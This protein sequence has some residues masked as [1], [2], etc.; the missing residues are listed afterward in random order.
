MA[1]SS[2]DRFGY[3]SSTLSST[4]D[5]EVRAVV[6]NVVTEGDSFQIGAS[7]LNR[8][9]RRRRLKV[10]M[11][12][13]GPLVGDS[14]KK[15]NQ[16]VEFQPHERKLV[17]WD[18]AADTLPRSLDPREPLRTLEIQV[19]ASA[20][21]R[22]DK[23]AL[24]VQIPVRSNQVRVSSVVYGALDG[25]K[26][27][28]PIGIPTKLAHENGRLDFTLTTND[29][30]NFDGVFQYVIDYPYSC[31][32]Q[33]LTKA[34]LA[35]QYVQLEKRGVKHGTEWRDPE[36]LIARVLATAVDYQVPNG[37]MA[38]FTPKYQFEDPYLSA[39]TAIAFSWLE[40]AGYTVPGKVKRKLIEY[41]QK[42][43][44]NE[45][46]VLTF[47]VYHSEDFVLDFLEATVGA[48]VV[49]ALAVSGELTEN[50][51]AHYSGHINQ[52][53]LFG[54]SQYLLA[55]LI[56]D[57]THSTIKRTFDRIMNHR[58]LVDGVVEFVESVPRGFTRI[59]HSDTRSL[60][61]VLHALTSLSKVSSIGIDKGELHALSN[62]VRYARDNLPC[63]ANTQDNVFCTN[64][65]IQFFDFI[66]S[67]V[68]QLV[69]SVDLRSYETESTSRL[70]D[71]WRF[72]SE[73]TRLHTQHTLQSHIFG[74][75]GAIEIIRHGKGTAFYNVELSY[76]TTVDE[77][78]NRYSGFEVHREYVA[79]RDRRWQILKPGDHIN[80]GEH[81][82]V[83]LYLNNKFDRH[84]V[85]LDDSVPGGLEPVNMN[86]ATEFIPPFDK[87]ELQ[88]ILWT[89]ELYQEFKEASSWGFHYRELGLQNVRFYANSLKRRKY[90]LM[91][92][93]QAISAGEFTV[94][95]THVEEMYRPI[96]FGKSEPWT[97][98]VKP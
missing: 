41:L 72:N 5:T 6:P 57:P 92:L 96:M 86:L 68:E 56:V 1:V 80:K 95:P 78:I 59:L 82:L 51:L 87:Y 16:H 9:D 42:F 14:E 70:A 53:D 2:D 13:T 22:R 62:A 4:K 15:Y 48:V 36:G 18:V 23:D 24:R 17:L 39:Y 81:V 84:H 94:L 46:E 69:A 98:K 19:I 25:E 93:G 10:E 12:T 97:F 26:T 74:S 66:D 49:H 35:M 28:I 20:G 33:E 29:D 47:G 30:V 31:W 71:G 83:N 85:M 27:K 89:S 61:S 8:A 73:V 64:A 63:W 76:L 50:E 7:I 11:Q 67:D 58:S 40:D 45:E 60:C 37:G 43:I 34:I 3:T 90:H 32:E 38:Y 52:M 91:W 55:S 88:R 75:H 21:D 54:L 79:F 77:R 65:L 44:K